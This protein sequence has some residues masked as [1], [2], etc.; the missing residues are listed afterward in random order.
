MINRRVFISKTA[1]ATA[2]MAAALPR[3]SY[4]QRSPNDTI[5][6]AII[7]LRGDNKGHP[8]W[9]ARGR[10]LDHYEHLSGIKNVRI[11]HVVDVDERNFASALPF[12]KGKMGRRSEDRDGFP[13]RARQSRR[14]CRDH[15]RA[16]SLARADD[17]H[18][19]PGWQ[20][21]LLRKADQPQHRR[22]PAHDRRGRA[23]TTVSCRPARSAAA[24]RCSARPSSSF[25][26]ADSG[27]FTRARRSSIAAAI[28]SA[29]WP[30][31]RRPPACTTTCG[32]DRRRCDR[33]TRITSITTG[34]SSGSTAP[35]ISATP[36]CIRSTP[37]AG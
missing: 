36:A 4:A 13:A 11:T 5:N 23:A 7:G 22:R 35:A 26:M 21:R 9:T 34:T 28:R 16:G 33:S 8:T 20:G 2:G 10:G 12:A 19:V 27:R 24:G 1:A 29:W 3:E 30:T 17:H 14:R 15:R 37:P 31:A 6:V 32:W 25:G 18:G